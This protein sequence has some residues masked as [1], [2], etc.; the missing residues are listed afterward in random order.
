MLKKNCR[1]EFKKSDGELR[2]KLCGEIDHHSAVAVRTQIDERI[3]EERPS[4]TALDLSGID[5][6]DSSGLGLVMGRY[7]RMQTIGGELAIVDPTERVMR[8]FMLSGLDKKIKIIRE[9]EIGNKEGKNE[10]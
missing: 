3:A 10:K 4:V 2:V 9:K 1:L 7:A 8:I 6:M 5:F